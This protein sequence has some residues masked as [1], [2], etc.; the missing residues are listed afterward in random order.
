M[1]T[2]KSTQKTLDRRSHG[3]I[4]VEL[5]ERT[6]P[7]YVGSG[8]V[9]KLGRYLRTE[10]TKNA[11]I[12]SDRSLKKIRASVVQ[13]LE[14]SG[15]QVHEIA[16]EAG[17]SF[18]DFSSIYPLYGELLKA[19]AD[20]NAVLFAVGGGSIGDAAGFVASTY[21]RGIKWVGLPTT[22]L[23]QVD[24][25]VG[26]KTAVNHASGKNL[27]GTFHQPS[28]VVCDTDF[29][30]SLKD[31]EIVSGLGE[32]FKYGFIY[33][34]KFLEFTESSV[35]RALHGDQKLLSRLVND[36][37]KW[38]ARAV[39][40]DEFDRKGVREAL[41]FGHTFGHALESVTKFEVFQHGEAVIW[42]M[43]FAI[44]LSHVRG[45][46]NLKHYQAAKASLDRVHVPSLPRSKSTAAYLKPMSHDKKMRN[47]RLQFVLLREAGRVVSDSEVQ[48]A[49]LVKAFNL[50]R[51]R[52]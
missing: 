30:S 20:R 52:T 42:G 45:W 3:P 17:E 50:M 2:G 31:S 1:K 35:E 15:W 38:K 47:G 27:I 8:I 6:Y 44:A 34:R 13:A 41:N 18:K 33:D 36:S 19:K 48:P 22:L 23:A 46:M 49:D 26:G 24:S 51:V 40:R 37:L 14:T 25:S 4:I 21:L 9:G 32:V 7:V 43:R 28:L 16:V 10:K 29:L 12:I 39:S 5:G 11:Y